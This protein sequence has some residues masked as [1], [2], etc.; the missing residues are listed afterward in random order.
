[1]SSSDTLETLREIM[2]DVFDVDDLAISPAT[3]A[4][5]IEEWDSLSH[6]RLIVA[7]ER[8]F[9]IKFRTAEIEGLQNVG[10]LVRAID[11]KRGA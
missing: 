2:E 8:R 5:D 9:K 10:E 7:V 3:T 11:A 6:I 1:M 4:E